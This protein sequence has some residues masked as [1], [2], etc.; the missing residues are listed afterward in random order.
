LIVIELQFDGLFRR[1][2]EHTK[3]GVMAY[4][5]LI[6]RQGTSVARGYGAVAC[7]SEATS[8]VAEYLALIEGLTAL[9]D[10]GVQDQT[11]RVSGDSKIVISQMLG[12][13]GIHVSR[14]KELNLQAMRLSGQFSS[15]DF[16]WQKRSKNKPAD[17]LTR[18]ALKQARKDQINYQ[19]VMRQLIR[20]GGKYRRRKRSLISSFLPLV[21]LSVF[22]ANGVPAPV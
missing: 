21:E 16:R 15:I 9:L 19:Q 8:N 13:S 10:M 11:V 18:H 2:G 17:H 4:G 6:Y 7:V 1:V 12:Q 20:S 5:W 22:Q 3:T 14:M